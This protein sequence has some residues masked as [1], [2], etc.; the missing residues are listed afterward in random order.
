[1]YKTTTYLLATLL[2]LVAVI[3]LFGGCVR[4]TNDNPFP[5]GMSGQAA[6]RVDTDGNILVTQPVQVTPTNDPTFRTPSQPVFPASTPGDF[7]TG[8]DTTESSYA[9]IS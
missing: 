3:A 2:G 4:C 6:D 9:I 8:I 1:M 5:E 7:P